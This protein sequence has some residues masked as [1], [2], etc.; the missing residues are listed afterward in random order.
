MSGSTRVTSSW[1]E[2]RVQAETSKLC[3]SIVPSYLLAWS[4]LGSLGGSL[5]RQRHMHLDQ[6]PPRPSRTDLVL[7]MRKGQPPACS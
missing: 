2:R 3:R 6:A 4:Q 7:N 5:R 1:N